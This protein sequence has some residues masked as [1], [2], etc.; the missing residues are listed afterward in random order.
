MT[1][2][3]NYN[4]STVK[5][6]IHLENVHT[7]LFSIYH[8]QIIL[9]VNIQLMH[10]VRQDR[11]MAFVGLAN[12]IQELVQIIGNQVLVFERVYLK[13]S[14]LSLPNQYHILLLQQN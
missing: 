10:W 14:S 9:V 12:V 8:A 3:V 1:L 11:A 4:K 7:D 13:V 6:C 2:N 5:I